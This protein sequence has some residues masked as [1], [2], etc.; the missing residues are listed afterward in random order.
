MLISLPTVS[1]VI[2]KGYIQSFRTISEN[3]CLLQMLN[4]MEIRRRYIIKAFQIPTDMSMM[5]TPVFVDPKI[6][7]QADGAQS[8]RVPVQFP[9]NPYEAIRQAYL[10]ETETPESP[11]TVASPTPLLD[12][13]PPTYHAEDSV[14]S[15][16]SGARPTSSDF[17][18]PLSLDHPLTHTTPTLVPFLRR[19]VRMAVRIPSAMSPSISASIAEV[20]AMS[21]LAFRKRFRSSY[22]S[23]PSSSPPDLPLRKRYRG[24]SELV[25]D[26]EEEDDEEEDEEIEESSDSDSESEGTKDE[27]PTAEDED[28]AAGDKGDAAVPEGQQRVAPVVKTAMGKPLGLG[29]VALRR[30][31]I[32]LREGWMPSVF[33][34]G[35]GSRS[36]PGPERPE[37]VLALRKPVLTTWI[38]LEDCIA[39]IDVPTYPPSSPPVQTLPSL[40]W[41]SGLLLV[42]PA[43]FIVPLP[44]SAPM[45]P[46]TVPSLVAS[47]ATAE[48]KG[49]LTKL[50]AQVEMQGGL[51]H[52]HTV[53]LGEL[54]PALFERCDGEIWELFTRSGAVRDE[55]F[56]QRY[57]FRSLKHKQESRENQK[58]RLQIA[59]ERRA[60]LDLAEIVDS[61]RRGQ[62][63]RGDV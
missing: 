31:K 10:V 49:H 35:Q 45:I 58:L 26:E 1:E 32:T 46:L 7:I 17:T 39:Y 53:R 22:E 23:S 21:D 11:H 41:S 59:E 44:I 4:V 30:Q 18:A 14:D 40:E 55:I 63:P 62:E 27:G 8:P 56:S 28:P 60:Q 51:I 38:D 42:S 52:D 50:G 57:R 48:A 37:R 19:T 13:T 15:D 29:F 9:E 47:L 43:P 36:V 5:S 34:V 2:K 54:S 24:T 12:S 16:T 25:E 61:I 33:E 6:F 3:Q 20:V